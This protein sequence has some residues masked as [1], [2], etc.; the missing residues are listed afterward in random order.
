MSEPPEH[1]ERRTHFGYEE[2]A[3]DDKTRR[4]RGVFDS[5]SDRYDLMNDL[6]SL[7]VH[8]LW[9]RFAVEQSGLRAGQHALDVAAGTG[10]LARAYAAQVGPDGHVVMTDI[11]ARMLERGRERLLDAGIG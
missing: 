4:V 7:G 10:D 11:N 8:R 5:V 2:V 6:M 9:K 3:W 1:G